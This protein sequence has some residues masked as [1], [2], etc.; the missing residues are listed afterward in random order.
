MI[1][2]EELEYYKK[3]EIRINA[4]HETLIAALGMLG[5]DCP[6]MCNC[7]SNAANH[8]LKTA[9][10]DDREK[11]AYDKIAAKPTSIMDFN[12]QNFV[13]FINECYP[14]YVRFLRI[15]PKSLEPWILPCSTPEVI[16][17]KREFLKTLF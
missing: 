11:E 5:N 6:F 8:I 17:I 16:E 7:I 14:E 15:K 3:N 1:T 13:D 2:E 10:L 4:E 9:T 12:Y